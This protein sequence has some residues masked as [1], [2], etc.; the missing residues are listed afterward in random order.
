MKDIDD[1]CSKATLE[2]VLSLSFQE[3]EAIIEHLLGFYQTFASSPR[4]RPIESVR[5]FRH[6]SLEMVEGSGGM[7]LRADEIYPPQQLAQ[8]VM[9][10]R[11]N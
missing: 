7:W 9:R 5:R 10:R 2:G 4:A 11:T 1:I 6:T 3:R 8:D